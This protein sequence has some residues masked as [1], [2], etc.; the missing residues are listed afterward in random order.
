M[1]NSSSKTVPVKASDRDLP[2]FKLFS[3]TLEMAVYIITYYSVGY[4]KVKLNVNNNNI[5][6]NL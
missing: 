1:K 6:Y 3:S 2:R 5:T 4:R